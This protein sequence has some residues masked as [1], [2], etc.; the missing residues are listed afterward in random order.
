MSICLRVAAAV[1]AATSLM[2]LAAGASSAARLSSTTQNVTTNFRQLQFGAEGLA[3]ASCNVTVEGSMHS[4]TTTKTAERLLGY[5]IRVTTASCS[6]P[7]TILSE[8]LPWHFRYTSFSGSLPNITLL[9]LTAIGVSARINLA[10]TCLMR[11]NVVGNF[12]RNTATGG[13]T[14]L[15]V[16]QTVPLTGFLC[17]ATGFLRSSGAGAVS[18]V[19]VTLI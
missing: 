6:N 4:R 3:T 11:A 19:T 7:M 5:I 10:S 15:T 1:V 16:E 2:A 18:A 12:S 13:I 17:P 14:G 8:T 9:T